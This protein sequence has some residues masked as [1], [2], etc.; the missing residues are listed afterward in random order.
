MGIVHIVLFQFKPDASPEVVQEACKRMLAL[1]DLCLHPGTMKPYVKS[2]VGGLDNSPENLQNG[3]THGFVFEFENEEDR[4]YY[5][6][7][8]PSHDEFKASVKD[9]LEHAQVVDFVPGIF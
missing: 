3:M 8:D 5:L 6:K 7:T 4:N 2:A 9:A 1:K